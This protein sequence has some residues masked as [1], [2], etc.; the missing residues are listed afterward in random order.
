[1]PSVGKVLCAFNGKKISWQGHLENV[2]VMVTPNLSWS[3]VALVKIYHFRM[4]KIIQKDQI[5]SGGIVRT[6]S[7]KLLKCHKEMFDP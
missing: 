1:M 6:R 3:P 2:W 4:N 7:G 5:V